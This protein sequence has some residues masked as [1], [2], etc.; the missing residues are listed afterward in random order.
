MVY[1]LMNGF[2]DHIYTPLGTT[3]NYSGIANLHNSQI[4]TA[5][6]KPFFPSLLCLYQPFPNNGF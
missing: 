2:I 1:V 5:P 3:S 6:A 4:N